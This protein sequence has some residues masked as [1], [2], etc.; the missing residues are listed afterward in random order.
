MENKPPQLGDK[1]PTLAG[2]HLWSTEEGAVMVEVRGD[3]V[4]VAESLDDAT[5]QKLEVE[6]FPAEAAKN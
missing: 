2:R 6:V 4:L 3:T 5:T 1:V